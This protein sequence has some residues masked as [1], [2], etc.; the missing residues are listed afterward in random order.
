MNRREFVQRIF[1]AGTSIGVLSSIKYSNV[2]EESNEAKLIKNLIG[3][4]EKTPIK[5]CINNFYFDPS[6][7]RYGKIGIYGYGP[8]NK[9]IRYTM[10]VPTYC[11]A[12]DTD[13]SLRYDYDK[14]CGLL[15][16][17]NGDSLLIGHSKQQVLEKLKY[18]LKKAC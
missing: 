10:P 11:I 2:N 5:S 12:F 17:E 14:I 9:N 1:V 16:I 6:R 3:F 8:Y 15:N 13:I 4:I 7:Y 18:A